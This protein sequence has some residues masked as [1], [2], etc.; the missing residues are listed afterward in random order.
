VARAALV[1]LTEWAIND[2]GLHRLVVNHSTQN[3]ASCGVA[4]GA[5]Y[6]DE[7]T[8]R[9]GKRHLDGW[10]DMHVHAFVAGDPLPSSTN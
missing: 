5:G 2:L 10:H 7:G 8:S 9:D 1:A 6:T 4:S 3:V